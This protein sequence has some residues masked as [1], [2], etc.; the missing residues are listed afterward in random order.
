MLPY[1]TPYS[2]QNI[3]ESDKEMVI[4]ALSSS[5][6]TQG[7]Y[8]EQFEQKIASY[9]NTS[10]TIAYN[11]ATS[12]LYAAFSTLRDY[13]DNSL[14]EDC[15]M[16]A[17]STYL[18]HARD[19]KTYSIITTPISFVSTAN[20]MLANNILPIFAD[21]TM[22]GNINPKKLESCI[23]EDTIAICSV[24]Y[25]GKSVDRVELREFANRNKILWISD[26]SH[27][28]G[29]EFNNKKIASNNNEEADMCIFSFH[30]VKPIT[31]C[32][33]GALTTNNKIFANNA[34]LICSHGMIKK[35][36]YN[37][38]CL[39]LGFNFRMNELSAA[40]GISQLDRLE[41]FIAKREEIARFYD[42][43]F[44]NNPYFYTP[45]IESYK[46]SSRHLYP[47]LLDPKYLCNKESIIQELLSQN[48]GVQV[49]YKPIYHFTLYQELPISYTLLRNAEDFW[50]AELS[51][52]CHQN[53]DIALAKNIADI[54]LRTFKKIC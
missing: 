43:Y 46:K 13:I 20:M 1:F 2:T 27:S 29:A 17:N 54:I 35:N 21:I 48:V 15:S 52:P 19:S 49:H 16:L 9:I 50:R 14:F 32:E 51:L 30:A 40:L 41:L 39:K 6:L 44:K 3:T 42:D 31:T 33:G 28:F 53:M 7:Q 22:D 37:H 47:V 45:S 8:V 25:G 34:R 24:D 5:H 11:S 23:R 10:H 38:D 4:K 18:K 12:A 36:H 26:S